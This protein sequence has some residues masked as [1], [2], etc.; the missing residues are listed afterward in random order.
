[1]PQG[2]KPYRAYCRARNDVFVTGEGIGYNLKD[3][4]PFLMW[5]KNEKRAFFTS[6]FDL[7]GTDRSLHFGR[8]IY[9]N[10]LNNPDEINFSVSDEKYTYIISLDLGEQASGWLQGKVA[11]GIHCIV[12]RQPLPGHK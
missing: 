7:S 6:V 8:P 12:E 9:V 5:R 2:G 1:M 10:N 4:V 11:K 3:V